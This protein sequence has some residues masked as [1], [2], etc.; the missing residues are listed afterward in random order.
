MEDD[1]DALWTYHD[2]EDILQILIVSI[3][4]GNLIPFCN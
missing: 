3:F 4:L 2:G 1:D